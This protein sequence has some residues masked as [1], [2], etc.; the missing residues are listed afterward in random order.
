M[1]GLFTIGEINCLCSK[2]LKDGIKGK[3]MQWK[4]WQKVFLSVVKVHEEESKL[5]WHTD[6]AIEKLYAKQDRLKG[7]LAYLKELT[8]DENTKPTRGDFIYSFPN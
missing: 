7:Q 1:K 3:K 8:L 6:L 2:T 4:K 5:P